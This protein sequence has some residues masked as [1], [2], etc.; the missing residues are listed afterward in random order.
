M[1]ANWLESHSDMVILALFLSGA[2][3]SMFLISNAIKKIK[4]LTKKADYDDDWLISVTS[5][6]V[7]L[8]AVILGFSLVLVLTQYDKVESNIANEADRIGGLDRLMAFYGDTKLQLARKDLLL[9]AKSIVSEEWG[10]LTNSKLSDVTTDFYKPLFQAVSELHPADLRQSALFTEMIKKLDE[11]EG[12]REERISSS[13]SALHLI[14]WIINGL[15]FFSVIVASSLGMSQGSN[16]R[17]LSLYLQVV[18]LA[19]LMAIVFILDT[20]FKGQSSV[21]ADALLFTIEKIEM[22]QAQSGLLKP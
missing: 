2:V 11:I 22:R 18:A 10:K 17:R 20:P 3:L 14:F 7:A 5:A 15:I 6:L 12:A 9:Y 8:S 19:G 16:V 1:L 4:S 13:Q 21:S